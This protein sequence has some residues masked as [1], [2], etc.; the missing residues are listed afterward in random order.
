MLEAVRQ[1]LGFLVAS[2]IFAAIGSVG[3][4]IAVGPAPTR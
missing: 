1:V 2:A 4:A 3:A